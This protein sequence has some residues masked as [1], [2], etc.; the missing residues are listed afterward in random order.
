[1]NSHL[2]RTSL[3]GEADDTMSVESGFCAGRT[4]TVKTS[5]FDLPHNL[6]QPPPDIENVNLE[7]N[8]IFPSV[9]NW[10]LDRKRKVKDIKDTVNRTMP[11]HVKNL[12]DLVHQ[13]ENHTSHFRELNERYE[14]TRKELET[15]K[16]A[17]R[18]LEAKMNTC[19]RHIGKL[20]REKQEQEISITDK[21]SKIRELKQQVHSSRGDLQNKLGQAHKRFGVEKD[22]AVREATQEK[23]Q[24]LR[25]KEAKLA[26]LRQVLDK[27]NFDDAGHRPRLPGGNG[28]SPSAGYGQGRPSTAPKPGSPNKNRPNTRSQTISTSKGTPTYGDSRGVSSYREVR[29]NH[30]KIEYDFIIIFF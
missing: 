21:E 10:L 23:N 17:N 26:Q 30:I 20:E 11:V 28:K 16:T 13:Y 22:R 14:D 4:Y 9:I 5:E 6:G 8:E 24:M 27:Q 29:R 18:R 3:Y 15:E 25:K 2:W 19:N 1:M 12:Q 7:D